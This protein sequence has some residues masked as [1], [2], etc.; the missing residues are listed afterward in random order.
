[1]VERFLERERK[2]SD[3][4]FQNAIRGK[5]AAR[6]ETVVAEKNHLRPVLVNDDN[7]KIDVLVKMLPLC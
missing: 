5:V 1:M 4:I 3:E 7:L 6:R 2:L